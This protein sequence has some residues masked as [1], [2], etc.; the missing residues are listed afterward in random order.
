MIIFEIFEMTVWF[1]YSAVG[2]AFVY[3]PIASPNF[4][5]YFQF[6]S[7]YKSKYDNNKS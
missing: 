2:L 5:F 6:F 7:E 3:F 4:E 1:P